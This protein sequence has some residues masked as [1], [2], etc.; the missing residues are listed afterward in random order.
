M[1]RTQASVKLLHGVLLIPPCTSEYMLH[2]ILYNSLAGSGSSLRVGNGY[3][4]LGDVWS[5]VKVVIHDN[6]V[7]HVLVSNLF[8]R[9]CY[10]SM[11]TIKQCHFGSCFTSER[12]GDGPSLLSLIAGEVFFFLCTR[13]EYSMGDEI[14]SQRIS[15]EINVSCRNFVHLL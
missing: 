13:S 8:M 9:K 12:C 6:L 15:G 11:H 3:G 5:R 2:Q 1:Q 7:K 14:E 10:D 4:V